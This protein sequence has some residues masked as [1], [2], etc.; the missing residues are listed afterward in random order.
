[1]AH[2]GRI[3]AQQIVRVG[4]ERAGYW[5]LD[6]L[7]QDLA[8]FEQRLDLM[9]GIQLS[10]G[11]SVNRVVA[12]LLDLIAGLNGE[13]LIPAD[14]RRE[15]QAGLGLADIVLKAAIVAQHPEFPRFC[16]HFRELLAEGGLVQNTQTRANED[17]TNK[18][19]E[20]LM[21][22]SVLQ[23]GTNVDLEHPQSNPGPA[24]PDVLVDIDGVRWG[25]AC[26]V[27]NA[28]KIK[29]YYDRVEDGIEQIEKATG[30]QR[31]F[32]VVN[33]KNVLDYDQLWPAPIVRTNDTT[34]GRWPSPEHLGALAEEQ[35]EKFLA[36]FES[37]FGGDAHIRVLFKEKKT[38]P[39]I[40][41]YVNVSAPCV[42][43]GRTTLTNLRL[44]IPLCLGT[45]DQQSSKAFTAISES[46]AT[47]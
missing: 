40:L 42:V 38:I 25:L 45:L 7:L 8:A 30:A 46:V 47:P 43:D 22:L 29:T 2:G 10:A 15:F 36:D 23:K 3:E 4:M 16:P 27:L 21:A 11:S 32:V 18:I 1:M 28:P 35:V 9:C 39:L 14:R 17:S 12:Q 5:S 26:K 20:L 34:E 13:H 33:L 24:N 44:L 31:G 19:F 6:S 41:N 37:A